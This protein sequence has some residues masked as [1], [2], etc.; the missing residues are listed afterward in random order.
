MQT[1]LPSKDFDT[2]AKMLDSK[3][4]NKQI[5]DAHETYEDFI[6]EHPT[7]EPGDAHLVGDHLYSWNSLAP[8]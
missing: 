5:L 7:G 3:R 2:V 1:F 6:A 8:T 4:L